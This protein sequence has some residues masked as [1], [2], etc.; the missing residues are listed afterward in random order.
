[1]PA[2]EFGRML[3]DLRRRALL[4]QERLA[5]LSGLGTRTVSD[6]ERGRTEHPHG[7][8]VRLLADALD[9]RGEARARFEAAAGQ[10]VAPPASQLP[11]DVPDFTGR[12]EEIAE[13]EGALSAGPGAGTSVVVVSG[14]AGVGKTALAVHVAHRVRGRFP[15]G[16]LFVN[17]GGAGGRRVAAG[18][19]LARALLAL[20]VHTPEL[21]ADLDE[22]SALYRAR[23]AD[24]RLLVLIDNAGDEAQVRPLLPGAGGSAALVTSRDV[25]AGLEASRRLP[26]CELGPE[27]SVELLIRVAGAGRVAVGVGDARAIV[28]FCGQLPLAVRIAGA[29]LATKAHLEPDR[30][31][32]RLADEHRRLDELQ[33]GDLAVRTS[34]NSSY[35]ALDPDVRR[36]F[37]VL[38]LLDAPDFPAWA[39]AALLDLPAPE[40][41][42]LLERLVDANL[43]DVAGRDAAGRTRYRLHDLLAVFARER[44][45]EE[46]A[47]TRHRVGMGLAL[48]AWLGVVDWVEARLPAGVAPAVGGDGALSWTAVC[49]LMAF[50]FE[51]RAHWDDWV[52]TAEAA[53]AA[54]RRVGDRLEPGSDGGL[55]VAAG[56]PSHWAGVSVRLET[57]TTVFGELG[58]RRWQAG[59]LLALGNV[60]RAEG[61]VEEAADTLARG[62]ALFSDL[63]APGWEAAC[64]LSLGSVLAARGCID[65]AEARYADCLAIFRQRGDATWEAYALR[66]LG[67]ARQQ[68]GRHEAAAA[69]LERC[70][71]AFR[72]LGDRLWEAHTALTLS[73]AERGRGRFRSAAAHARAA[74][75]LLRAL[76]DPRGEAMA[77]RARGAAALGLGQLDEALTL[78]ERA[79][80]AFRAL[81]DPI[82]T[83]RTTCDVGDV[84]RAL[85]EQ[86]PATQ[87]QLFGADGSLNRYVNVYLNDEDVR[88]L[89]GLDTSVGDGDTL[90]ILPAMAGGAR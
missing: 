6:L 46:G 60:R 25:L 84:L 34:F 90:V 50:S 77:L 78:Y 14:K 86:H 44:L 52:A 12:A 69:S 66:G 33:A 56:G 70:L 55:V 5:Q 28:A 45:D 62:R 38:G 51:L 15:D 57:C 36:I 26:L 89:D 30:L 74:E 80:G 1:M 24:R 81:G 85:A 76:G 16:Q 29:R 67:Y 75:T 9:L 27:Q 31:T 83:A 40:A 82:G 88:V 19:A 54:A 59:A 61:R 2:T 43:L 73:A 7:D 4:S 64:L 58:E 3:R 48:D 49:T 68:H 72:Q 37:G 63:G 47:I 23:L 21:P 22:R 18:E 65:E 41:Q 20:G 8:T 87:Q 39:P 79:L 11:P 35:E 13:L 42:D 32:E 17:L 10:A 53:A 71:P